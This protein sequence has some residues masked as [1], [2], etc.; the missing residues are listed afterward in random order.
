MGIEAELKRERL[1][2]AIV[3]LNICGKGEKL[4]RSC[5]L[6]S[7]LY[8]NSLQHQMISPKYVKIFHTCSC[9]CLHS[10]WN[11]QHPYLS[12]A[13]TYFSSVFSFI[14]RVWWRGMFIHLGSYNESMSPGYLHWMQKVLHGIWS[15]LSGNVKQED[16]YMLFLINP[17]FLISFCCQKLVEQQAAPRTEVI[18]WDRLES[19]SVNILLMAKLLSPN[20]LSWDMDCFLTLRPLLIPCSLG[21]TCCM[22]G[23]LIFIIVERNFLD[24]SLYILTER[25][26]KH[27]CFIRAYIPMSFLSFSLSLSLSLSPHPTPQL[28]LQS[29]ETRRAHSPAQ[30]F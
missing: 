14:F 9:C 19:P 11:Q 15:W 3:Q 8:A 16:S 29:L 1:T 21:N 24:N 26:L 23:F 20:P 18:G 7:M 5:L 22:F 13:V 25:S 17:L 12:S 4:R 2:E 10:S 30:G 27:L 6:S 28:I